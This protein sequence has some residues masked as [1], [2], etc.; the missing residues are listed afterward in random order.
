V[1]GRIRHYKKSFR[2]LNNLV[3]Q[4]QVRC[5]FTDVDWPRG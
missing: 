1:A 3:G 5:L 2:L 4:G